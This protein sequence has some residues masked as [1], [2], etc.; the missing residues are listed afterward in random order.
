MTIW[1]G[2]I[3]LSLLIIRDSYVYR[4][5][6]MANAKIDKYIVTLKKENKFDETLNYYKQMQVSYLQFLFSF[7][8]WDSRRIIKE[9]YQSVLC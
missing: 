1:L 7:W 2:M 4:C 9:E 8:I 3:M 5:R 6:I